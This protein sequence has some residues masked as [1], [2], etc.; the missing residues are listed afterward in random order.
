MS[1]EITD[2]YQPI[3]YLKC[4]LFPFF[5][6]YKSQESVIMK[7]PPIAHGLQSLSLMR[8]R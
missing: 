3:D 1:R 6:N 4:I 8:F 2:K 5:P 7:F